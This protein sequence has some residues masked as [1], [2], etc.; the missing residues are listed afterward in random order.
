V[1]LNL[2]ISNHLL[3][4]K[5]MGSVD[6]TELCGGERELLRSGEC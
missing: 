6:L 1:V 5:L 2:F 3:S 4:E